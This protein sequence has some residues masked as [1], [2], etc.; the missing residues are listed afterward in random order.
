[1][2]LPRQADGQVFDSPGR[3]ACASVG[4]A[5]SVEIQPVRGS[6][7]V[8]FGRFPFGDPS[9]TSAKRIP[10]KSREEVRNGQQTTGPATKQ[11]LTP[12]SC[13]HP[14]SPSF[15]PTAG[16]KRK[17]NQMRGK[18]TGSNRRRS[19]S[20]GN[21]RAS[22]QYCIRTRRKKPHQQNYPEHQICLAPGRSLKSRPHI[23]TYMIN[24]VLAMP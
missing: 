13:P 19:T 9:V 1:M 22:T 4:D 17:I 2:S 10:N 18:G 5:T 21:F 15:R 24:G 23:H 20:K 8:R 11:I 3:Q 14:P 16:P 12:F 6:P 7:S